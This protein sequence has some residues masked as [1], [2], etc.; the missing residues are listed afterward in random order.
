MG[1]A[2]RF[3]QQIASAFGLSLCL[4]VFLAGCAALP[5]APSGH[6]A[7]APS[8]AV[9]PLP[10]I[11]VLQSDA[12][13]PYADVTNA[14]A[15]QW[16]GVVEIYRLH[17]D[18]DQNAGTLREI[19]ASAK[20]IVIAVGLPAASQARQLSG[21]KVI[22]CQ[23][24]NY[25]DANLLTPWMKGVS[26]TPPVS[27]QF[28]AW[29]LLDPSVTRIA[30]ITGKGLHDLMQEARAAAKEHQIHLQ[31]IE[32][33]SDIEMRYAFQRLDSDVRGLWL[34][35]DNRVLSREVLRDVLSM[36]PSRNR[37]VLV[38]NEQLLPLGGIMS[39]EAD[40]ADVAQQ[41]LAR[42]RQ[43][44]RD[45]VPGPDVL[46]LTRINIELNQGVLERFGL[47]PPAQFMRAAHV[48]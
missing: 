3:H 29:K 13:A 10:G 38:F 20:P 14:I 44:T 6:A 30:V 42:V 7:R 32:V 47:S 46:G 28:R 37:Q 9:R 5:P 45:T 16:Q 43:A 4:G 23:V 11:A 1:T 33:V 18:A 40:P 8:P 34:V 24:F 25:E 41:V 27:A 17:A 39:V 35:P 31:H 2:R 15:Q 19:Q 22:F 48:R 21:K 36:S 12:S 26:A